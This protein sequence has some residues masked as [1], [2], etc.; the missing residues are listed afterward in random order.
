[1]L[2]QANVLLPSHDFSLVFVLIALSHS[3]AQ[4]SSQS[5]TFNL[6]LSQQKSDYESTLLRHQTFIETLLAN[7]AELQAKMATL[8]EEIVNLERGFEEKLEK[9]MREQE[10][11]FKKRQ[12]IFMQAEKV[13]R[14]V[15]ITIVINMHCFK[16]NRLT[17]FCSLIL[18]I[19]R[20]FLR[21]LPSV[22]AAINS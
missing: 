4:L 15:R 2:T 6:Q 19:S 3:A 7:K 9:V 21:P 11:E 14:S 1:M 17:D 22:F 12:E 8:S 10:M 5:S 13:K 16:H 20:P 18:N